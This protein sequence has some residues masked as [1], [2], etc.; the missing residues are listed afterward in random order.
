MESI[1]LDHKQLKKELAEK[2]NNPYCFTDISLKVGFKI[3]LDSH[4]IIHAKSKLTITP[5]YPEFGIEVHFNNK[6]INELSVLSV[7][8]INQHKFECQTVFSARFDKQDECKQVLDETELFNNL[9]INHKS[10]ESDLNEIDVRSPL[11]H[12]IQ[13]QEMKD[14]GWSFDKIIS[15]TVYFYKTGEMDSRSYV[16]IPMRNSAI[17]I[18]ENGDNYCFLWSVLAYLH[19][20]NI[21]HP[22]KVSNYRQYFIEMNIDRFDFTS[23]FKCSDVHKFEQI[24]NLSINIFEVNFHQDQNNWRQNLIHIEVSKNDSDRVIDSIIYKNHYALFEKLNVF[25]GDHQKTFICRKCL[26]S[27]T[28]E[29]MLKIHKQNVK[30]MI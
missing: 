2:K 29:N 19:P 17:L 16:K 26:N 22:N 11:E 3:N 8:L 21:I 12:Q 9:N 15:M 4:H 23:G 7:K 5:N 14:S 25:L 10:T 24:N 27:Y 30:K 18:V 6:I 28:S 1:E 13:Q 20:C